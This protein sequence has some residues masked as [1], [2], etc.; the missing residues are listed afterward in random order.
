MSP[1]PIG[2]A[3]S[4]KPRPG[5]KYHVFLSLFI[6]HTL[7][8]ALEDGTN[9]GFRNVGKPQSDAGE[10]PKRIHTRFKTRR[11]FEIRIV[12][13][14]RPKALISL[15]LSLRT[16]QMSAVW[17]CTS[18]PCP[19]EMRKPKQF[20]LHDKRHTPSHCDVIREALQVLGELNRDWGDRGYRSGEKF[21]ETRTSGMLSAQW[22]KDDSICKQVLHLP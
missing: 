1:S 18:H 6:L 16:A 3:S 17:K 8:P 2:P 10:I 13:I 14:L 20:H 7:H 12:K 4:S 22:Y 19:V 21:T 5:Y 15:N 11:K 9:R